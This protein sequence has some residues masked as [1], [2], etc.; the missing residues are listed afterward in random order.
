MKS[1]NY[2]KPVSIPW[3][4]AIAAHDCRGFDEHCMATEVIGFRKTILKTSNNLSSSDPT[5]PF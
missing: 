1:R 4:P 5:T 2:I 3:P